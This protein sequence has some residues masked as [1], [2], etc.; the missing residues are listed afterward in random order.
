MSQGFSQSPA[1]Q[2]LCFLLCL[3]VSFIQL[4]SAGDRVCLE[5][6]KRYHS[7]IFTLLL[8]QMACLSLLLLSPLSTPAWAA[9]LHGSWLLQKNE[10]AEIADLL[11]LV[12]R[13]DSQGGETSSRCTGGRKR[14]YLL[15]KERDVYAERRGIKCVIFEGLT[16]THLIC[17]KFELSSSVKQTCGILYISGLVLKLFCQCAKFAVLHCLLNLRINYFLSLCIKKRREVLAENGTIT[18]FRGSCNNEILV[19]RCF[20]ASISSLKSDWHWGKN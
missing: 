11:K 4:C 5:G 3:A 9:V 10:K 15:T 19:Y 18:I 1:T 2:F 17:L 8:L 12:S 16:A 13:P 14:F 7:N 6:S 20:W